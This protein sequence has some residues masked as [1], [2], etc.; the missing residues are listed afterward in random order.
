MAQQ[1]EDVG[2]QVVAAE[3]LLLDGLILVGSQ[4]IFEPVC[5]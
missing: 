1:Q 3:Q 4:N 5:G 2:R